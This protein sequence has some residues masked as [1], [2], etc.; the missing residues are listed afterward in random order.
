[1]NYINNKDFSKAVI[2]YQEAVAAANKPIPVTNY[3]AESFMLI[4]KRLAS[5]GNFARYTYK[6]DMIMD[7][8]ENCL[9]ALK[10]FDPAAK[11]RSGQ[12][13]AFSY[14][15][16]II[17]FAFLRRIEK[18]KRQNDVKYRYINECLY[19]DLVATLE[20]DDTIMDTTIIE[21][22]KQTVDL[23]SERTA[24]DKQKPHKKAVFPKGLEKYYVD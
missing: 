4:A 19:D 13:N 16:Q 2:E 21:N 20:Q 11:T 24:V 12:V 8:V 18:E 1:M 5:K 23:Y 6:D 3:I 7:G 17:Y 14:F 22:L 15:T 9:R 10:S